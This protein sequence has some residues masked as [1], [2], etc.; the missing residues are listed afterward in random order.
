MKYLV[1]T[2]HSYMLWRF[3]KDLLEKLA[4][5][6][7]VVIGMPYVGH[8]DDFAAEGFRCI[9]IDIDRRNINPIDDL[10]LLNTYRKLLKM[11]RPDKVITYSIK[12]N[13][14][15][16]MC[17]RWM[18]IPYFANVQGLGT[19]FQ[20][21]RLA[22]FV[23][24]LYRIAFKKVR[25]VFFE[26]NGN[27]QDF[28][29]RRIISPERIKV[30]PGAGINLEEFE[31]IDYPQNDV[32]RFLFLGRVM[33]EKG[34]DELFAAC[35]QLHDEGEKFQLDIVG[36]FEDEYKGK[37][38]EL[39]KKGIVKFFGFQ[40]DPKP[41]YATSDCVVLPSYHEGMS[42]VILEGAAIGRPVITSNIPGCN[43]GVDNE[44]SGL[45]CEKQDVR[46][47]KAAMKKILSMNREDRR[48]MG[49]NGRKKMENEFEKKIVVRET[50]LEIARSK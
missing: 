36:F 47:L 31:Y 44:K 22:E 10:K 27:A 15:A 24:V 40:T 4:E 45:L 48:Q 34:I 7:E 19:A 8:E 23:T 2:N 43:E 49:L 38:E 3:R 16:G 29:K 42:N 39:E 6:N 9:S 13:I 21:K 26:N 35:E 46:S 25:T 30:L 5:D 33:K 32:F 1:L 12:P 11:E 18:G 41:Y 28:I 20:R 50:I 14:Y 17:C 37:V